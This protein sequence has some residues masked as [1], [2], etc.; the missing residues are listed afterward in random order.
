MNRS[1]SYTKVYSRFGKTL[2]EKFSNAKSHRKEIF[3]GHKTK[4]PLRKIE[5]PH[6][7]LAKPE[8]IMEL[9]SSI[10]SFKSKNKYR[11]VKRLSPAFKAQGRE[12]YYHSI[13]NKDNVPH[14]GYYNLCFDLTKQRTLEASMPVEP[15]S[16]SRV[17]KEKIDI[18]FRIVD[19]PLPKT[20][21][22]IDFGK[23]L[24]RDRKNLFDVNEKRFEIFNDKPSIFS[25]TKRIATPNFNLQIGHN[26]PI[27]EVLNSA[28]YS[29][30]HSMVWTDTSKPI[31]NFAK[32]PQRKT[33]SN[34]CL[35][36]SAYY[37]VNFSQI[38]KDQPV[39]DL[40]KSLSRPIDPH[41]PSFMIKSTGR[42]GLNMMTEKSLESNY[43]STGQ[44]FDR[45]SDF[46]SCPNSPK[47]FSPMRSQSSAS[48]VSPQKQRSSSI[49]M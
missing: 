31:L 36:D 44:F 29:P 49:Q 10:E 12:E 33:L 47:R 6:Q 7:E 28:I 21:G 34:P 42:N 9:L 43:Y 26:Y 4:L 39:V 48:A 17:Q 35:V 46:K 3:F 1:Q 30:K 20:A 11:S 8:Q 19:K 45:E 25:K 2:D 37:T 38:D 13:S 14:A 22:P 32:Y 5:S 24:K 23:Q 18:D 16:K 40:T 27:R 15:T 41:F